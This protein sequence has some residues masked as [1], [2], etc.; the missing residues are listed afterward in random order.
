VRI[1]LRFFLSAAFLSGLA[2]GGQPNP[3]GPNGI[4]DISGAYTGTIAS[5]TQG[6]A[7]DASISLTVTQL[8]QRSL[9][10]DYALSGTLKNG[11]H[12]TSFERNGPLR[13]SLQQG[14]YPLVTI[15][16]MD[17]NCPHYS[18]LYTGPY[19]SANRR[20]ALSGRVE[21][22]SAGTCTVEASYPLTLTLNR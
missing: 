9:T 16:L 20:L 21:I 5:V 1:P 13:G 2:C 3:L 7:L 22:F 19:S 15:T 17:F 4:Q 8:E 11:T 10:G 12:V 14:D 18:A 6:V